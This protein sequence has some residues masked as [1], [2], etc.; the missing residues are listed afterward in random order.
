MPRIGRIPKHVGTNQ[1][2]KLAH[3][4]RL[5]WKVYTG[6]HLFEKNTKVEC[7]PITFIKQLEKITGDPALSLLL[8]AWEMNKL[9]VL[10]KEVEGKEENEVD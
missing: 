6:R 4:P 9:M 3:F 10:A 7:I 2:A 8:M 1:N 5:R